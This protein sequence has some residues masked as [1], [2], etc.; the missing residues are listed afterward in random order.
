LGGWVRVRVGRSRSRAQERG[1]TV[2]TKTLRD[3]G[4]GERVDEWMGGGG[5]QGKRWLEHRQY[6]GI[7]QG[8]VSPGCTKHGHQVGSVD[9]GGHV[10]WG[11][12]LTAEQRKAAQHNTTQHNTWMAR[13]AWHHDTHTYTHTQ[14]A[15][16]DMMMQ[17]KVAH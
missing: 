15:G 17:H 16:G 13:E 3:H 11:P 2:A 8:D 6:H 5:G 14:M 9:G 4:R 1:S 7:Q 10:Q 12:A